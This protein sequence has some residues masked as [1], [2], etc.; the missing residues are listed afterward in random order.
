MNK[1]RKYPQVLL[2]GNGLN[3][4]FGASDW[5]NL[6]KQIHNNPRVTYEQLKKL[7]FPLQAVL[8]TE[9][10][11]DVVCKD[12]SMKNQGVIDIEPLRKQ[13]I[14][15][16]SIPFDHILTTNYTY[17]IERVANSKVKLDGEYCKKLTRTTIKNLKAESK[18]L[19]HTYNELLFEGYQHRV[20]HIHGENRKPQS[21]ILGHYAYGTLL[22]KYQEELK[23]RSNKQYARETDGKSPILDSWL[24]AF[25]MGDVY[26]LGFGFD[27]SE[28]D[29]WWLL[30][31]K[32]REKATHGKVFFYSPIQGNELRLSLLE[33]YG[34][35]IENLG[36][37][38]APADYKAFYQSAINHISKSVSK[39]K[40]R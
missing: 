8:A 34:V 10:H 40:Q 14:D 21:L 35:I 3:R 16:L 17:E 7:P 36:F 15:L 38:S 25:I 30:N 4:A 31:R 28:M 22:S 20:W 37:Y 11:V 24:D 2:L 23:K 29:L 33:A 18:Y 12:D 6:L 1:Q 39:N 27:F 32:K 13:M 5:G 19:L 9:D 26:V